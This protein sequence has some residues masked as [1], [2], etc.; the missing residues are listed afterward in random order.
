M[1]PVIWVQSIVCLNYRAGVFIG[2]K[3][4][5]R[6]EVIFLR[7]TEVELRETRVRVRRRRN[8]VPN[9]M[10]KVRR[11]VPQDWYRVKGSSARKII[12]HKS[13]EGD[14][15]WKEMRNELNDELC[16]REGRRYVLSDLWVRQRTLYW[17][18]CMPRSCTGSEIEN[19]LKMVDLCSWKIKKKSWFIVLIKIDQ[20]ND[21][22]ILI[23]FN[24]KDFYWW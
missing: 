16:E 7:R 2:K 3:M 18:F 24:H 21:N 17:T 1:A 4:W 22:S 19:K 20:F 15:V 11:T 14:W 5:K 12:D 6:W 23:T 13:Q 10:T 9:R 8:G